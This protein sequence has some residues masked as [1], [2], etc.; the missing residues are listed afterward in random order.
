MDTSGNQLSTQVYSDRTRGNG[1]KPKKGRFRLDIRGKFFT[2]GDGTGCPERLWMLCPW[3]C[4][5]PD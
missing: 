1:F 5:K 3:K 2:E 4:L